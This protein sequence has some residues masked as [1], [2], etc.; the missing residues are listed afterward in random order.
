[1]VILSCLQCTYDILVRLG[2]TKPKG[3]RQMVV[4]GIIKLRKV[5]YFQQSIFIRIK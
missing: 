5:R 1:M 3:G 2:L 4:S